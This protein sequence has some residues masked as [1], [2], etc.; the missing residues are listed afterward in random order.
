[1][2]MMVRYLPGCGGL[3]VLEGAEAVYSSKQFRDR[4]NEDLRSNMIG[5]V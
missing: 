1:M 2:A 5:G 3:A 4:P